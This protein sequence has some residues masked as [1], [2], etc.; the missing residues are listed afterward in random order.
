MTLA[1]VLARV[2]S[3]KSPAIFQQAT[4]AIEDPSPRL[5]AKTVLIAMPESRDFVDARKGLGTEIKW[6]FNITTLHEAL[7]LQAVNLIFDLADNDWNV[8][9]CHSPE[10]RS[11]SR[12]ETRLHF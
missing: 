9:D 1:R 6:D 2:S 8:G 7:G 11:L 10:M 12:P 5:G 3:G 4:L